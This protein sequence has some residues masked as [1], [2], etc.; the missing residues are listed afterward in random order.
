[1]TP[2]GQSWVT[3]PSV[4]ELDDQRTAI[5]AVP[6]DAVSELE[7]DGLADPLPVFR[8]AVLDAVVAVGTDAAA[9]V[10]LLQTPDSIRAFATWV[11][12]RSTKSGDSLQL[13]VK[14][15]NRQ[16]QLTVT[17]DIDIPA[18]ADFLAMAFAPSDAQP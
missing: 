7:R 12:R 1:M 9:L 10:T 5:V 6:A 17:G 14:R 16:V 3:I 11:R 15:G 18:V 2:K 4:K 8:G 13:S